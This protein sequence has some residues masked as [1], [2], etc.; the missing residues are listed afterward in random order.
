MMGVSLAA[1]AG[2]RAWLPLLC[3]GLLARS[4]YLH[5]NP[6]FAFLTRDDLLIVCGVAT[7]LEFLGDK[8]PAVDNLLDA[9]GT[10]VRPV[11]GSLLAASVVTGVD[12]LLATVLGIILG[13]GTSLTLH[14][15]KAATR[16]HS[17]A[18]APLHGGTANLA[19]SFGEDVATAGGVGMALWLPLLAFVLVLVLAFLCVR[20]LRRMGA[21]RGNR[22]KATGN[23]Q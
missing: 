23:R 8:I 4:G 7:F 15:G 13:G 3:V 22:Q 19:L 16:A 12:P 5:L 17:T 10:F 18:T 20:A 11:A 9:A 6:A 14:L 21:A 1:C 2:L